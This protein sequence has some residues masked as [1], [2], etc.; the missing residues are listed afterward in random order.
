MCLIVLFEVIMLSAILYN[1]RYIHLLDYITDYYYY[2]LL[3][4]DIYIYITN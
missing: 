4:I 3:H 2:I 1:Y